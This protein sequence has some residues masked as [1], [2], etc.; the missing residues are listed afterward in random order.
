MKTFPHLALLGPIVAITAHAEIYMSDQQAT[1][2]IFPGQIF[3]R[4]TLELNDQETQSIESKSGETVRS[5]NIVVWK[6]KDKSVVFIDQV[7]G[8]HEFITFAVGLTASGEVKG[9]EILEYRE[10][11]GQQ[12]REENW[13]KQ[14][15]GKNLSSPLKINTDIKNISGATLSSAHVTAGV[16]RILQT[17]D[18]VRSR[19]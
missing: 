12:V 8:K 13:K 18:V 3:T 10:S 17:Y 15:V 1:Q 19:I 16:K 9:I 7:L 14:F 5:K 4:S 2:S 6:N 11:Y